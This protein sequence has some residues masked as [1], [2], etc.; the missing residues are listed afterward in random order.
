MRVILPL[1]I[2]EYEKE[3][4]LVG[5]VYYFFDNN[6]V[7]VMLYHTTD[8]SVVNYRSV[9]VMMARSFKSAQF[10]IPDNISAPVSS[11]FPAEMPATTGSQNT[12]S[13]DL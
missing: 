6:H 2:I 5:L 7:Y 4:W 13:S 1:I 10:I 8:S 12:A 11:T 3:P 9:M